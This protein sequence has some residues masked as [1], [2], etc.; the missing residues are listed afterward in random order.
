MYLGPAK[1]QTVFHTN[2]TWDGRRGHGHLLRKTL[3]NPTMIRGRY[4]G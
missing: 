3:G 4:R 2:V 1:E